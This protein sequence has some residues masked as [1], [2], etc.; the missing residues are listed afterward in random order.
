M[1]KCETKTTMEVEWNHIFPRK[2]DRGELH[3]KTIFNYR[4]EFLMG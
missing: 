3:V 4:V 2:K 1:G